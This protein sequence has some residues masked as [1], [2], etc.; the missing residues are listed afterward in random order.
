[1]DWKYLQ[2][3]QRVITH[4]NCPDGIGSAL[5]IKTIFPNI[6]PEFYYHSQSEYLNLKAEEGML[7]CDIIPPE[8]RALEFVNA[9]AIVL[10][11]HKGAE[12][13]VKM[14]RKRGVFA[15]EANEPGVSGTTLAW[16]E[17][18]VPGVS[19]I[20]VDLDYQKVKEFARL[21]GIRDTWQKDHVDFEQSCYQASMLMFYDWEYLSSRCLSLFKNDFKDEMAVG[22]NIYEKRMKQA[23]KCVGNSVVFKSLGYQIAVFNDPEK[24]CSD[25]S[26]LH[27]KNG[28]DVVAGFYYVDDGNGYKIIYSLRSNELFNVADFSKSLGGG[29]HSKAA[30][31]SIETN[32][33]DI[34]P[35]LK[36]KELFDEYVGF[37]KLVRT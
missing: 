13:I 34:N 22:R 19:H 20:D 15:D 9:N 11:H 10:D 12:H 14:F 33:D 17:V 16:R 26:E 27:R 32:I 37:N 30:G 4:A 25:V 5:V 8:N 28:V 29:G 36:F 3:V 31:F 18:F 35:F 2:D 1:M 24:L 7:F 21:A 23:A 6:E